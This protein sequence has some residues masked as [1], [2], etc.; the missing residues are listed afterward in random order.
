MYIDA[1][2]RKV[3]ISQKSAISPYGTKAKNV[4]AMFAFMTSELMMTMRFIAIHRE[5]AL[6]DELNLTI[7]SRELIEKL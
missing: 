7:N 2:A 6:P 5:G 4:Y 3:F 1:K